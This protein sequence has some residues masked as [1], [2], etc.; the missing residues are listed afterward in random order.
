MI[1]T[2][3]TTGPAQGRAPEAVPTPELQAAAAQEVARYWGSR[4]DPATVVLMN[5]PMYHS[6]PAAYGMGSARLGINMVLQ[7]RFD[8]E[9]MLRLIDRHKVSHMHIVPT[10]FV[11]LLRLPDAVS[12]A[13]TS[14]RCAGSRM[15]RRLRAGGEARR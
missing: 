14:L 7:P 4:A 8:A 3:G 1:Y 11:R 2:S 15:G 6:A 10:M 5:G 12:D 13:T 9:D